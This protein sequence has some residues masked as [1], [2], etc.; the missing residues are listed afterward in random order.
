MRERD[1]R[2]ER[3]TSALRVLVVGIGNMGRSH[4]SAYVR[5]DDFEVVGLC[6][7][8]ASALDDLPADLEAIARFDDYDEALR[9]L[10]PDVV[11]I[12][13]WP[14]TH[15][16][17]AL[18]ALDAG[19]H[20]FLEKPIAETVEDAERVVEAAERAGRK[21]VVGY[22]LR[23][24]P[25]WARFVGAVPS[26]LRPPVPFHRRRRNRSL[27]TAFDR[28]FRHHDF[29]FGE[30]DPKPIGACLTSASISPTQSARQC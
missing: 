4:A 28:C 3:V 22:I 1:R 19:A 20:V 29:S 23:H 9:T 12:C 16:E 25:S 10:A 26:L 21:L 17:Y 5:L 11:C 13:T 7:R 15:A 27:A 6:S 30:Q 14:D 2:G 8:H 24:H 18:R